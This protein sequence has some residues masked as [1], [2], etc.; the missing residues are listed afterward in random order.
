MSNVLSRVAGSLQWCTVWVSVCLAMLL[1]IGE[2]SGG[3][4]GWKSLGLTEQ[5]WGFSCFHEALGWPLYYQAN[6]SFPPKAFLHRAEMLQ[7]TQCE[8]WLSYRSRFTGGD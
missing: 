7:Q 6:T 1:L 8:A 5:C 3:A 2:V 4:F